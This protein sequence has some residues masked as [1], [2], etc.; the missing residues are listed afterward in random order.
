[1]ETA[2]AARK[3]FP[4]GLGN[5]FCSTREPDLNAGFTA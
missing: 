5:P 3:S 1:M 4:A 2:A